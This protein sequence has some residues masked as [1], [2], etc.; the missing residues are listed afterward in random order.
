VIA[1]DV[2]NLL[3]AMMFEDRVLAHDLAPLL[4]LRGIPESRI[5]AEIERDIPLDRG[6]AETPALLGGAQGFGER[7]RIDRRR[8]ESDQPVLDAGA[9]GLVGSDVAIADDPE[10]EPG[11]FARRRRALRGG[12]DSWRRQAGD[13][14]FDQHTAG[15]GGWL[16]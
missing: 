7:F 5:V 9:C 1:G 15:A 2:V 4:V 14:G 13:A 8:P 3:A 11:A 16:H 12:G 10:I 6:A